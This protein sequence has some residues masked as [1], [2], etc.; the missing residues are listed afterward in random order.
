LGE[1]FEPISVK[2]QVVAGMNYK[3]LINTGDGHEII[4]TVYKKFDAPP[5]VVNVEHI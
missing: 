1:I 5:M 2:T 4:V 3:F